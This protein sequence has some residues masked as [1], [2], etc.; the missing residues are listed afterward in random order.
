MFHLTN[1]QSMTKKIVFAISI[2]A[3]LTACS[4]SRKGD[5]NLSDN[6]LLQTSA[7]FME[8]PE[9]DKIKTEH[10]M[11]AF[12]AG[13][14]QQLAEIDSIVNNSEAPTFENTLVAMERSGQTLRRISNVFFG[15][16][17]ANTNDELQKIEEKVSPLLAAHR[18]AIYLNDKLFQRVKAV[19]ESDKSAIEPEGQKLIQEYYDAFVRAGANLSAEDK[20]KLM[21]LNKE[22]ASLTT[23]FGNKLIAA[24]NAAAVVVGSKDS[25]DGLSETEIA[26]AANDAKAAGHEGKYLLNIT[27]TTQQDYLSVLNDRTI[28]QRV[29]EAS[30]H[31]TDKGGAHDTQSIVL[32]LA[33]LRAQKARLLGFPN[34]AAWKLQDQMAKNPE[35]VLAFVR[36]IATPYAPQAQKDA[37]EL[38]AYARSK[39]FEGDLTAA[40]WNYYADK[41]RKEKFGLDENEVKQYFVTDSV[42]KNGVFF[43]ANKLYGLTFKERTDLPV[44]AEDVRVYDVIDRDG[45]QLALFYTDL[46]RRPTKSG[47]AWMSNWVDQSYLLNQ[48]PVIY[49][50]CNYA[51]G[52]DGQPS[53]INYDEVTTLFHEFGHALHGM[54][55]AQQYPL[56]SGTNVARDFVEMPSQLNEHWAMGP[57]VF[58]N[59]AKH[60]KTQEPMSAEL[61]KKIQ[62]ASDFNQAYSLGENLAAVS[63]DQA[64]H[65]L[66]VEE[67]EA[68]TDVAKF[69][70][71]ALR[72]VGL[73]NLQIPPRYRS[74]YFRHI[75]SNGYASGYYAYL[76][77][78][79]LDN[80]VYQWML[81]NGGMTS[82]NG[83]RLRDMI[84]SR[85]NTQDFNTIF[86]AFT[87]LQKPDIKDLLRARG[88]M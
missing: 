60:W 22:E 40:D 8:A 24:T 54:F 85:G 28:R 59:Y 52:V 13:M 46:Y 83:Q 62:D 37:A 27:N 32:R 7:L 82:Q 21:E 38:Q 77:S 63:L 74:S 20:A 5:A 43:A 76:W 58:A 19:Y 70:E 75:W 12:E 53:L 47:G 1:P 72:K 45:N 73:Y 78:E 81:Q 18:D 65:T 67:A 57:E 41:L 44:Y 26:K 64:W 15:L 51:K 71:E 39:G 17:G 16:T 35:T 33:K 49:N 6:P 34:Y 29:L 69:E 55:A 56:L 61:V 86:T 79:V 25:L 10:F 23:E 9:F 14:E 36:S 42:L 2:M 11:P 3:M 31:R 68:I 66:T 88:L 80:N 30:I 87:G 50:V 4:G 48:K 84:L